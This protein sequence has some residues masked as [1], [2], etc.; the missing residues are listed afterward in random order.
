MPLYRRRR[1]R[2][3]SLPLSHPRFRPPVSPRAFLLKSLLLRLRVLLRQP[4]S[5]PFLELLF[6]LLELEPSFKSCSVEGVD[7]RWQ[8]FWSD[9]GGVV[10]RENYLDS[11]LY[12]GKETLNLCEMA[13]RLCHVNVA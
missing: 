2:V 13:S 9:L 7:V 10:V 11:D 1:S 6:L 8:R 4:L 12:L 5:R 3:N